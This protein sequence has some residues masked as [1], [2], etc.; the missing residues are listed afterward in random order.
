MWKREKLCVTF[1]NSHAV[2]EAGSAAAGAGLS[3][4]LRQRPLQVP[5]QAG[6]LAEISGG[7]QL[8]QRSCLWGGGGTWEFNWHRCCLVSFAAGFPTL[9]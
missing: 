3:Q 6:S 7:H 9:Y 2:V 8:I 5:L 1:Q 4:V